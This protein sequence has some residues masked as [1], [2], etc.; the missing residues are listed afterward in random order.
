MFR[1]QA[2]RQMVQRQF[3]TWQVRNLFLCML[4]VT[5]QPSTR[6]S[7]KNNVWRERYEIVRS[8]GGEGVTPMSR[9][10]SDQW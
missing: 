2:I 1:T 4:R 3:T 7:R 5:L 8:R 9:V 6:P 10:L